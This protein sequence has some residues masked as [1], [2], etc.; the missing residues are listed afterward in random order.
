M[1]RRK[2]PAM[3]VPTSDQEA[4]ALIGRY[5]GEERRLRAIA[6]FAD[7]EIATIQ[8]R[9][10]NDLAAAQPVQAER[11]TA[12]KAWWEAGGKDRFAGP[13]KRSADIAGA[14]VGTRLGMPQV[15]LPKGIKAQDIIDWL[16][17]GSLFHQRLAKRLIRTKESLDKDAIIRAFA[18]QDEF[19]V[20]AANQLRS[21]LVGVVQADEFYIDTG[22]AA[23]PAETPT[24][25]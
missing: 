24:S 9:R 2:K 25:E 11:F 1:S 10:D 3:A 18:S 19:D 22:P 6:E 23:V 5:V 8:R 15:K 4:V 13:K 14:K 7:A 21:K 12:I 17:S 20:H 16:K